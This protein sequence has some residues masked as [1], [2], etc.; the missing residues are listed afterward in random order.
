MSAQGLPRVTA[1]L[2]A[3]GLGPDLRVV[4]PAVL[5][6]ARH[7]GS[8]VHALIEAAVYGYIEPELIDPAL[9]PYLDAWLKFV[10]ES[11]FQAIAAE[12]EVRHP[13][14]SYCGH[15]DV[16]G[17]LLGKRFILD[18]KTGDAT[19]AQYQI[20]AYVQAWN[21]ERPSE[22]VVGGAVLH[23]REDGTYRWDEVTLPAAVTVW[24]AAV[25]VYRAQQEV[26]R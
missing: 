21:A 18:V 4:A 5:E 9:A 7:R 11:G 13:V 14:W 17:W 19:G 24:Y 25:M 6:A 2:E 26:H 3:V 15:P 1:I 8:A 12:V 23:L 22:T 16:I 20:A 10:A